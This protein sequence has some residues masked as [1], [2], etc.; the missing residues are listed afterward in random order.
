MLWIFGHEARG[1]LAPQSGTELGLL[2]LGDE[3]L[4]TGPPG[5]SFTLQL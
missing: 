5:K 1:F 3:V 4:T 2:A